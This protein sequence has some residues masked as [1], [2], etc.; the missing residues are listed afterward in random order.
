MLGHFSE[1]KVGGI[2]ANL[3]VSVPQR[4]FPSNFPFSSLMVVYIHF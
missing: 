2:S 4:G 3:Q 1:G